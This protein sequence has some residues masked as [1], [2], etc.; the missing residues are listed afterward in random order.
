MLNE[1][2][3][4][5]LRESYNIE[6]NKLNVLDGKFL[7][8]RDFKT[9]RKLIQY[10]FQK[11]DTGFTFKKANVE[12]IEEIEEIFGIANNDLSDNLQIS[13][14]L[15]PKSY[16]FVNDLMKFHRKMINFVNSL[17]EQDKH[18]FYYHFNDDDKTSHFQ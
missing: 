3:F 7:R 14:N 18:V 9:T 16:S 8:E 5:E 15:S 13:R 17:A 10:D 2:H 6:H 4:D 12:D 11:T 1:T